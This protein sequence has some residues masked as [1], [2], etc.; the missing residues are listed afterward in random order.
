LLI[1]GGTVEMAGNYDNSGRGF[2]I[3]SN[4]ATLLVSQASTFWHLQA[5][6]RDWQ[7]NGGVFGPVTNN[8][9][10]TLAGAGDGQLDI[11]IDGSGALT[12]NGTGIW[13]LWGA[14]SYSGAT[15]INAGRLDVDGATATLG[16]NSAVTLANNATAK[17]QTFWWSGTAGTNI[18]TSFSIG[19]LAGG[20]TTGGNVVLGQTATLTVGTNDTSTTYG[21]VISDIW[22]AAHLT[23]TG[24]GTLT[25]TNTNYY[26]GTTTI[27]GGALHLGN[28]TSGNDGSLY[29][30]PVVNNASL[31]YNNFADK[32]C[33]NLISGTGSL[34]K[35][36]AGALELNQVNTYSGATVINEG[37]LK[38]VLPTATLGAGNSAV[39]LANTLGALLSLDA[40]NWGSATISI[41][42]LAGGGTTGGNIDLHADTLSVGSDNTSTTFGGTMYASAYGYGS[43]TKVGTGTLTLTNQASIS[44]TVTISGG[45]LQMGDGTSGHDGTL[46]SGDRSWGQPRIVNNA[47]LV[48]DNFGDQLIGGVISGTGSLTKNGAGNLDLFA[49]NT[50]TGPITINGGAL[51]VVPANATLGAGS[52]AVTIANVAGAALVLDAANW[53]P[54]PVSIGSLAGGGTTGGEVNL[55]ADTLTVGSDNTSTTFAGSIYERWGNASLT[56]VGSG[57]LTLAAANYYYGNTTVTGGTLEVASTGSIYQWG[58]VGV[59][60]INT[61]GTL[62]LNG[63]WGGFSTG[64]FNTGGNFGTQASNVVIDGGTIDMASNYWDNGRAFT[65][66]AG[67]ATLKVEPGVT[68]ALN[69]DRDWQY[70]H[71]TPM[72]VTNNHSLTLDGAGTGEVNIGLTGTGSVTKTGGGSWALAGTNSYSGATTVSTGTLVVSHPNLS[73]TATL[74]IASGAVLNLPY[75]GTDTVGALVIHGATQPDGLYD[76]TNSS[77]AITGSGKIQV[78]S[79][80]SPAYLAWATSITGFTDTYPTHDPDGDGMTNQQEFA[81]NLDPTSGASSN[82]IVVPFDKTTGTF[83]YTRFDPLD[84]GLSY[85]IY[86]ST[87]LSTWTVDSGADQLP[88]SGTYAGEE[89]V[90]VTLS[91]GLLTA[92]KLFVRV[93]AE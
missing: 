8:S 21:G 13:Q 83:S 12:K 84:T 7:T 49:V 92:S 75:S 51:R 56:K 31:V 29:N 60:T 18:G 73:D 41:G 69:N 28:G 63:G 81:F 32:V 79:A 3:G 66:G 46:G 11:P 93:A 45:A 27:S 77:G 54:G 64:G 70:Y 58:Y 53:G 85:T 26:S 43:L 76:S 52:N 15:T 30:G 55:G 40:A 59:V 33:S 87:N 57:T 2:S 17:L 5:A 20:G 90:K 50:F 65:I 14:N 82:P 37:T 74:S 39:T 34:I 67:G 36:G 25:L 68:W 24:T 4:G 47:S 71:S 38:L 1:D 91:P 48:Y 23:K 42:S 88:A 16:A 6:G 80:G 78:G 10:L 35:N 89:I 44:D 72:T 61:G 22:G 86:T 19:S 9:N 62:K